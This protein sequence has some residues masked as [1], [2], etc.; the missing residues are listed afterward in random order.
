MNKDWKIY[1]SKKA[2]EKAGEPEKS[3]YINN[4]QFNISCKKCGKKATIYTEYNFN[5][6]IQNI[7]KCNKCNNEIDLYGVDG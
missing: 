6:C 3:Y 7:I 2:W 4:I 1:N 5:Y